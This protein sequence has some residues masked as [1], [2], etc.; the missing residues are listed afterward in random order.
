MKHHISAGFKQFSSSLSDLYQDRSLVYV[1][2]VLMTLLATGSVSMTLVATNLFDCTTEKLP[3][4][5]SFLTENRLHNHIIIV[6]MASFT[7]TGSE[8]ETD[9]TNKFTDWFEFSSHR[10]VNPGFFERGEFCPL[11]AGN[12]PMFPRKAMKLKTFKVHSHRAIT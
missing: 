3:P 11:G 5:S 2:F 1:T 12:N 9:I 7:L 6:T 4:V 10:G 8:C